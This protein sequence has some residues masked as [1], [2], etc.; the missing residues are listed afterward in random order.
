MKACEAPWIIL[1]AH[2][3]T[4]LTINNVLHFP[5][6][7]SF[8]AVPHEMLCQTQT[9]QMEDFHAKCLPNDDFGRMDQLFQLNW[10]NSFQT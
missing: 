4:H 5:K 9:V 7:L 3:M 6:L 8:K 2:G 10:N 1:M